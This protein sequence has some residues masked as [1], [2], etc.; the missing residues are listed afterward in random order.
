VVFK[1]LSK[2][3]GGLIAI[4]RSGQIAMPF[5]TP[6]MARGCADSTGRFE[7]GSGPETKKE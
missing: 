3:D 7:F 6:G 4:S 2:G 5:N 1:I